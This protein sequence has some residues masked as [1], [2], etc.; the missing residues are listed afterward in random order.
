MKRML[1]ALLLAVCFGCAASSPGGEDVTVNECLAGCNAG[2]M[3]AAACTMAYPEI[4]PEHA[5][6]MAGVDAAVATCRFGCQFAE[7]DPE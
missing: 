7:P 6:C 1:F 2:A 5:R 3:G 4:G